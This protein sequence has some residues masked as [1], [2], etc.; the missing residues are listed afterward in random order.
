M[1]ATAPDLYRL[2]RSVFYINAGLLIFNILPIYPLDGGQILRSLLW[3]VMGRARSLMTA[4][5]IG[6]LGVLGV[7][8]IAIWSR[9]VW[10]GAISVYLLMSCWGGLK[11]AQQLLRQA[12]LPRRGGFACP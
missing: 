8:G 9:D 7:S 12:R 6:I 10:L 4:T 3:F 2:L 5:I 1:G 11:H